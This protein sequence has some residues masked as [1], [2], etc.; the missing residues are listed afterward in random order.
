LEVVKQGEVILEKRIMF[1]INKF[2]VVN[3]EEILQEYKSQLFADILNFLKVKKQSASINQKVL[4][5]NTVCIS[6]V[7]RY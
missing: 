3:D 5:S 7:S 6:A 1:V 2:D 4:E